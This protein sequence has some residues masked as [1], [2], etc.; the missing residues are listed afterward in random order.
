M[1]CPRSP[2][3]RGGGGGY[4]AEL[5]FSLDTRFAQGGELA[6]SP[7]APEELQE[8]RLM[9]ISTRHPFIPAKEL[10]QYQLVLLFFFFFPWEQCPVSH[11]CAE[12]V[13]LATGQWR[14]SSFHNRAAIRAFLCLAPGPSGGSCTSALPCVVPSLGPSSAP[15]PKIPSAFGKMGV[16]H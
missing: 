14:A 3:R 15:L 11:P 7:A 1:C 13:S 4:G 12:P 16:M 2:P 8:A 9:Q 10:D 5:C 6:A